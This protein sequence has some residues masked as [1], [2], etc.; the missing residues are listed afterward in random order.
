MV[1]QTQVQFSMGLILLSHLTYQPF[2][3]HDKFSQTLP[4]F[5]TL[6]N[7]NR[8]AAGFYPVLCLPVPSDQLLEVHTWTIPVPVCL[9]AD[10]ALLYNWIRFCLIYWASMSSSLPWGKFISTPL[11]ISDT[12]HGTAVWFLQTL[13]SHKSHTALFQICHVGLTVNLYIGYFILWIL[14][15]SFLGYSADP[16]TLGTVI[17]Q[18]SPTGF[19]HAAGRPRARSFPRNCLHTQLAFCPQYQLSHHQSHTLT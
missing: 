14:L 1:H 19:T 9:S 18:V 6:S 11:T 2:D 15:F 8:N 10:N 17:L 12:T 5:S 16:N 13:V 7:S 4:H 3:T